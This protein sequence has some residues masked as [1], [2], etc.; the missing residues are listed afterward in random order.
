VWLLPHY[1]LAHYRVHGDRT[2]A[3]ALLEP[4]GALLADHGIGFLPAM[5]EGAAPHA[6]TGPIAQAWAVGEALRVWHALVASPARRPVGR[7]R[8]PLSL[9][10]AR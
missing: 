8:R 2:R 10:G 5:V 3:L 7:G 4:L 9:V 1:A 6:P